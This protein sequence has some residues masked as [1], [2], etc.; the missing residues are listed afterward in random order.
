MVRVLDRGGRAARAIAVGG[1][2]VAL[3]AD[4]RSVVVAAAGGTVTWLDARTRRPVAAVRVGGMPIA[5]AMDGGAAWVADAHAGTI[6]RI[7]PRRGSGAAA[8]TA[9]G[10]RRTAPATRG[11]GAGPAP[12]V[13]AGPPISVGREPVAIAA[14]DGNV[15]VVCR[16]DRELVVVDARRGVVT[17]TVAL[18]VEPAA[19]AVDAEYVWIAAS[20]RSAVLRV[21]RRRLS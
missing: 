11:A 6:R 7:A 2:P 3:A 8:T 1:H 16:G 21:D 9:P 20:G 10:A 17:R 18:G 4:S 14:R 13:V 12:R 15:Y 5:V 19:I